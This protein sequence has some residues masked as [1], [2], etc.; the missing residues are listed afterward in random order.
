M[1]RFLIL[2]L[3]LALA[4]VGCSARFTTTEGGYLDEKTGKIYKPLTEAFE[5]ISGGEEVGI[6]ESTLYEDDTLTFLEIPQADP[7]R[8]LA[9]ERGNVYCSDEERPDAS[10]W[11]V[12][13][14]YV[15]D[16]GA[17]SMATGSIAD[18]AVIGEIRTLW[19]E[20]EEAE[21]PY[22]GLALSRRL[23]MT[24]PDCPGIYYCVLYY[25]Y[26]DGTA[27]FY[28]RFE[29]RAVLVGEDLVKKIPIN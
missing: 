27:Y 14:I 16:V 28:D 5:A 13:K 9:D 1:R 26:G 2:L 7:A 4:L 21:L 15:C 29:N 25:V 22:S 17:L 11:R 6:W 8:F 23:K 20:G 24:S 12:D 10:T 19:Y 18:A 3:L